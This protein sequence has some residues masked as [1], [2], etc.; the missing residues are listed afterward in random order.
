LSC[1]VTLRNGEKFTGI[2]SAAVADTPDP[3]Y[4][5]KSVRK[6]APDNQANGAGEL[7]P[8]LQKVF[9]LRDVVCLQVDE[10]QVA[11]NQAKLGQNGKST[12]IFF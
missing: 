4:L 9:P 5:L 8:M 10:I 3:R 11:K 2:F 1:T 6:V 7:A 12:M